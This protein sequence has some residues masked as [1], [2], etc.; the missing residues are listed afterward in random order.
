MKKALVI[1][2][3][4]LIIGFILFF[5][6]QYTNSKMEESNKNAIDAYEKMT[7]TVSQII[8]N[9]LEDE[10]HLCDI[11]SN[12]INRSAESGEPMTAEEAI[13]FIRKAK[14]SPEISGHLIFMDTPGFSGIST[15]SNLSNPDDYSVSYKNISIFDNLDSVSNVDGVV[16]LTRAYTN[17]LN[18][19]QSI[20]FMN[21]VQIL[22]PETG[23]LKTGLLMRV[24]PLSRL[25]EKLVFLK[26]EYESV[27]VSLVDKDG[28]YV[29]H[30]KSL[31]NNNFFEY[32]KSYNDVTI[33]EYEQIKREIIGGTGSMKIKN[34]KGEDCMISYTPLESLK[35]W[36]L[37]A[38][39]PMNDLV[40]SRVIDWLL[41]GT[42]S[43]GLI[44]LLIYNFIV[45]MA[46][47]RK[48]SDTAEQ[49][50]QANNAK[51]YFLST[52]SHD[53]RTPMN[54]IMGLNEMVLR[55]SQDKNVI[56]Y[57]ENI[58]TAGNTLLGIINDILDFSKIEA[59]KMDIVNVDYSFI[60]MLNDLVNMVQNKAEDKGLSFNMDIER[61]I[62]SILHG[63][64]IRI[65]QI[66]TNI[67][68]NA[69]KYTKE[70]GITFSAGFK[71]I[72]DKPDS[73]ILTIKVADTGIGIKPEDMD[74]LF[75]AFERIEEKRNRNIEGTG[76]G[77]T[78][79]QSFLDMMGSHLQ[80]ESVYGEGSVF[81][82]D[83]EQKVVKWDPVGN[84]EE[85]F[86]QSL[87]E[88]R[89]YRE[90]F[91]A[92]DAK[93]LVV[94]DNP[95]NL[96]VFSGLL[97]RTMMQID[98]AESGEEAVLL[99]KNKQFD[100][101]FLDH[102]MPNKDGI[103]TLKEMRG[104]KGTPNDETP[105][106]CLT[107]NA[108]SGMREMYINAGFDDYIT[109]PINPDRLEMM[110]LQYL[111]KDKVISVFDEN[112]KDDYVLPDFLYHLDEID[113][114]SGL[115]NCGN[116]ESYITTLKMY[117]DMAASNADEIEKF[118]A[119]KDIRNT[120]IKVHSLKSTSRVIGA[121]KLGEFAARLEK[122]GDEG[123][124]ETLDRE[125]ADF[126]SKYR[127][128][129]KDLEPLN[130]RNDLSET[131]NRPLIT[132]DKLDEFYKAISEFYESFDFDSVVDVAESLKEYRIPESE[133]KK[134]NAIIK[135]VDNY[136]YEMIPKIIGVE[137]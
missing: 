40:E 5:T 14:T 56:E 19:V 76:L 102:M 49:A 54:A 133:A 100:V 111:P 24:V 112:E 137:T 83:L 123:D 35:F 84:Y 115:T 47:N 43:V 9:Y 63:D 59:G 94:D 68:S 77:M 41:L 127:K 32:Y 80:V 85:A 130:E 30:G 81:S 135:A 38:F 39:I 74:R 3:N 21:Y 72:E 93:V 11:W 136:D 121:L 122:A 64:E 89:N 7:V 55:D 87:S 33:E 18:G 46:F 25:E 23:E 8:T 57:S 98:T 95:I 48:L 91:T 12:Y 88:R 109:K 45:L 124:T 53:I 31:K 15:S 75:K 90:K 61:E 66:I 26:G 13:S 1:V 107:A 4:L 62:P 60:S 96:K 10:Q 118:W 97:S 128:L 51:S 36:N 71:K 69:V 50:N 65:K 103:E 22:D 126:I 78:I 101:I 92:P 99:Y 34:S 52:M 37:I 119:E 116:G 6:V 29:I 131:D 42:V 73:I 120:T 104:I 67:L 17:P 132:A 105:I 108:I 16:N 106:I 20:A 134:V 113:V 44:V 110:L 86:K 28:D 58:K 114:D 79:A 125:L 27:E 117:L 2:P 70:G 129:A 82:F